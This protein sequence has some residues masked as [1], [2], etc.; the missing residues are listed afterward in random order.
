MKAGRLTCWAVRLTLSGLLVL[1]VVRPAAAS[2]EGGSQSN[3]SGGGDDSNSSSGGSSEGSKNSSN[4]S[5]GTSDDSRGS[6][7]DSDNSTQ[8]SPKETTD[9]TSKG[10]SDWTTHSRGAHVLSIVLAVV[11]VGATVA[12]LAATTRNGRQQ[13]Q[14]TAALASFMRRQHALLTHDIATG[15]GPVLDAW[16]HDLRLTS[17]EKRRF[18]ET[19]EG[20]PDQGKLLDALN[21][22]IDADRARRFGAA[23]LRVTDRALGRRRTNDLVLRAVRATGI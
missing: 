9:Y 23:F 19:L 4:T 2:G 20:S 10:S 11:A 15:Q 14:A 8:N 7:K 6:S 12:G 17:T 1:S 16:T 18:L 3:S 13:Q 5:E 22:P 21:G